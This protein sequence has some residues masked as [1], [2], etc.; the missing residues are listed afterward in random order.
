MV[1]LYVIQAWV[2]LIGG[3]TTLYN[4]LALLFVFTVC[5]VFYKVST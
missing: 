5:Y 3:I 2:Y 1:I 4:L